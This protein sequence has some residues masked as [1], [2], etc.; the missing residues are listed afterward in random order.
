MQY[1]V[2]TAILYG[3]LYLSIRVPFTKLFTILRIRHTGRHTWTRLGH[4]NSKLC[5]KTCR[6][7]IVTKMV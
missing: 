4:A 5:L 1:S 6:S 2:Y 7:N 3:E